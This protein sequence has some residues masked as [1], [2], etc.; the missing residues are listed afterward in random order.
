MLPRSGLGANPKVL[1][2]ESTAV[3]FVEPKHLELLTR[4]RRPRHERLHDGR[5]QA[6][7]R[8]RQVELGDL[9]PERLGDQIDH[10]IVGVVV[11]PPKLQGLSSELVPLARLRQ[12][13]GR[14]ASVDGLEPRL[15]VSGDGHEGRQPNLGCQHVQQL[16]ALPQT[17]RKT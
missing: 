17:R 11:R 5:C 9:R 2:T 16:V 14:V 1:S 10:L 15:A 3:V 13:P 6:H 7:S 12:A 4:D 8:R